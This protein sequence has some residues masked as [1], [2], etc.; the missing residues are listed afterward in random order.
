MLCGLGCGAP[1]VAARAVWIGSEHDVDGGRTLFT[2]AAGVFGE[3]HVGPLA[4]DAEVGE[5]QLL[6]ELEP[7]GRGVLLRAVDQ[8][9]LHELGDETQ[10]R[11]GY[12]DLAHPRSLPLALP[13]GREATSFLASGDGLWWIE[14]CASAL[15]VVPLGAEVVLARDAV[16]GTIVPLRHVIAG[17]PGKPAPRAGCGSASAGYSVVSASDAPRVFL[18]ATRGELPELRAAPEAGIDRLAV[19]TAGEGS[20][21]R[22]MRGDLPPGYVPARLPD[23]RCT[24]G[25]ACPL[26]AVDPDGEGLTFAVSGGDCRLLRFD[27]STGES[28]CV[29]A[30]D[31]PPELRGEHLVAAISADHYVFRDGLTLLR[32]DWRTGAR[33][34]RSLPGA[35][36]DAFVRVTSDG[37][38]VVL[39]ASSGPVLRVDE[40]TLDVLSL[41]QGVCPNPQPPVISPSGRHVAWTCTLGQPMAD[42]VD[43]QP[44]DDA[45][46]LGDV[47]RVSAAGLERF[48]GVPMWA[49]AIDDSGDLLLHSRKNRRLDRET[50]LPPK[51]P[52]NLYVLA[53]DGELARIDGLEPDPE[54]T[55]GQSL[56][57]YRWI[58]ASPL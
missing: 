33:A 56:G 50:L 17:S 46:A 51:P 19:P 47:L 14:P 39:G 9:W 54:Q 26:A 1:T 10:V 35:S 27:A 16:D 15:A 58:T 38:V 57:S 2:Y 42:A 53:Q 5:V 24:G 8:G 30:A 22:V 41:E 31:A 37:R 25:P 20:L 44:A 4:Q 23:L 29:V 3:S 21:V 45:L 32:H 18:V 11:G 43:E 49:L 36:A 48:Q 28:S 12:I 40:T 13:V 6:V 34:I 7:R 52:R 55:V